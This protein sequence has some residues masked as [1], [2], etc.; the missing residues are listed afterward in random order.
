M[1]LTDSMVYGILYSI[2]TNLSISSDSTLE[3]TRNED[4][5]YLSI[6]S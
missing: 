5:P 2:K 1:V 4:F 3:I 6:F